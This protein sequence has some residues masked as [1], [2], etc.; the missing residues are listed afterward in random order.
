[1][2]RLLF[3]AIAFG[4]ALSG[5]ALAGEAFVGLYEHDIRDHAAIGGLENGQ[6][7]VFGA[8]TA[9][10]DELSLLGKPHVH[11]LAGVNT[12]GHTDYLAAG[13]DWRFTFGGGR[14][15]IEPGIGAAV[16]D[17]KVDLPSPFAPGIS[18]AEAVALSFTPRTVPF[19]ATQL[20]ESVS[21]VLLI[22]VLLAFQ[23]FRRHDG[24]VLVVLMVGYAC[25]RFLNEAIR[26][27]PTYALGL[28]LSQW[29]SV[30]ILL[31]AGVLEAF[32]RLTQS[33]LPPG[34]QPLGAAA[35]PA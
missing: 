35:Q 16:H 3:A 31:G 18:A 5:R 32:L 10:L 9:A 21:M 24:Q 19:F 1:M 14:F 33:K 20:Y 23:P 22:G 12:A 25:H 34:P 13:L 2:R 7:I 15:Y 26:I 6:Q 8:R 17:G 27:E 4:A 29:I 30:G 28:T 11:L